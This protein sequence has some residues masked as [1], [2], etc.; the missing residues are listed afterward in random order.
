MRVSLNTI[1]QFIDFDLPPVDELVMRIN[2]QLG[3]VEEVIDLTSKYRDVVIVRVVSAEKHPNAD[4]LSIC[5]IDD[6]GVVKDVARD[7]RGLVQV[8]CGAPNAREGIFAAWLPPRSTVPTTFSTS[9]PFVLEAR[10]LRGVMS[11]GMLAA[12]DELDLGSDHKGIIE[13]NPNEVTPYDQTIVAGASF[14]RVFGLD[15]TILEIENKM[16]THR[17]D[18]FGQLG[19]AREISAIIKGM[20]SEG[21]DA[22]D[23]RFVNPEWYWAKP[24]L[25]AGNDQLPLTVTN[26][27]ADQV[28]R[29]MAVALQ[30]VKVVASPLW[31]QIEL[32]RLGGKP[33]NAIV[34]AT[35]YLML[36]T[37]QPTH[38][39][40]YD[41][42]RAQT[43]GVRMAR[44]GETTTLLNGKSYT[45]TTD[46]IVIVDGE[47]IVGLGGVMGGG[48]S[49]V[50][51]TTTNIVLEV[52]TFDMYTV[53]KTSMRHGLFTD[54]VTR[55]N[56]GQSSLQNDRVL[57]HL[58]QHIMQYSGGAQASAVADVPAR[59]G[60]REDVSVRGEI[61]ITTDFINARL[62]SGLT[63]AEIGGLLRRVNFAVYSIDD[64]T[65]T[66][67]VTAPFWRTDIEQREDIVEEIGR[68]YGF[69][70]LPRTLPRRSI[71]P[72]P[73]NARRALK[74][75][76]SKLLCRAGA[77]EVLTYSFVHE[78]VITNA[79]QDVSH[80]YQLS[81]AL[82]PDLQYYRLSVLPSLLDKVHMDIKAGFDGFTLFEA[83]RWHDKTL[84][85][86]D[87]KLPY[88]RESLELVVAHKQP[89][90]GAAYFHARHMV[91][92]VLS[93]LG[94]DAVYKP[95]IADDDD[96]HAP[97]EVLRSAL[98]ETRD[99]VYLGVVGE[100]RASTRS[101][102]KLPEYTAA[103]SLSIEALE[104]AEG[105]RSVYRALSKFPSISQD[106]SLR[107]P[108]SIDYAA[109]AHAVWHAA[110]TQATEFEVVIEPVSRYQSSEDLTYITTT[111]HLECTSQTRTLRD[112]DVNPVIASIVAAVTQACGA[113]LS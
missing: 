61:A 76:A 81:N 113:E 31:L 12:A 21:E 87:D 79:N 85:L 18:L 28:P 77:N 35:N 36:L 7:E 13:I 102:F 14:A 105:T 60:E 58:M 1:R 24:T 89:G 30:G 65:D 86:N 63:G 55:F 34:D 56:K 62:G 53:R 93:G 38:A 64:A 112:E 44:A 99:G 50:S 92:F 98:I 46:D 70:R 107:V 106:L 66:L 54:A 41:T 16:F 101:A 73:V 83:G 25:E 11:N 5:M 82:S 96:R 80:A 49:E 51:D 100:L 47:G 27:A 108:A 40:D 22:A 59:S 8:V 104:A 3:G 9:E 88:E 6:G 110:A 94:I 84:G 111:F 74:Q 52:A 91:E 109:L 95:L 17:P 45:L 67:R 37:A 78:R 33:I 90:D 57:A 19:V 69:E 29:F 42:L 103:A 10:E 20:P 32:V 75:R 43:L 26:D 39:Y 2:A 4:K 48:N 71:A 23:M 97:Y 68:L 72:A 15:D